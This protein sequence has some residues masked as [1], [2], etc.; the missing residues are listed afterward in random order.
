MEL[1]DWA[2]DR[3]Y[4]SVEV[5]LDWRDR[6]RVLFGRCLYVDVRV[7]TEHA[8]GRTLGTSRAWVA[9]WIPP[10]ARRRGGYAETPSGPAD[11]QP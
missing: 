7:S 3:V 8:P 4:S 10:W 9:R 11:A 1:E 6:L 5:H 2:E